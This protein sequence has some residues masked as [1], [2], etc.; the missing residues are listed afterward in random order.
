[1]KK[2][3]FG[4]AMAVVAMMLAGFSFTSCDEKDNAIIINGKEWVKAEVTNQTDG[5]ATIVANTPSDVNRMLMKIA[6]DINDATQAG[7]DYVITIEAPSMES[8]ES[9]NTI[10]IPLYDYLT[11]NP[12][13][14]AKVV[15]NFA[16][17]VNTSDEP[18]KIQAKGATGGAAPTSENKVEINLPSTSSGYDLELFMPKSTVTL[19][20]GTIDELVATTAINTL[21]IESG[22]TVNW[23]KVKDGRV[24]VKDGGKVLGY[25]R[26]GDEAEKRGNDAWAD[27]NGF[28]PI[29]G[30]NGPDVYYLDGESEEP[31][32]VQKLKVIKGE[33]AYAW[34]G[35]SNSFAE[36]ALESITIEDGA[37]IALDIWGQNDDNSNWVAPKGVKLIQGLGNKTAKIYAQNNTT[38]SD[39]NNNT[40]WGAY[41]SALQY[42]NEINNVTVNAAFLPDAWDWNGNSLGDLEL[43]FGNINLGPNSTDCDFISPRNIYGQVKNNV[44]SKVTNCTLTCP[45]DKEETNSWL[46]TISAINSKLT[47]DYITNMSPICENTTFKAKSISFNNYYVSG[48][49]STIKGCKFETTDENPSASISLPYQTANRSSFNFTFDTCDFAKGFKLNVSYN[50]N[51]PWLDKDGKPVTKAFYWN[52]L[53]E[54]GN[55][56]QDENYNTI[57]KKSTNEDDVPEANK[58]N[59]KSYSWSWKGYWEVN[60]ENG[61]TEESYFKDYKGIITFTDT[62]FDG[63]AITKDTEFINYVGSGENEKGEIATVTR[64]IIGGVSYKAVRDTDTQKY[65]LVEAE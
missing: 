48:N 2:N 22:V 47:A 40:I 36:N 26:N 3:F 60:N 65:T 29:F 63:K 25:L 19:N 30:T 21:I 37:A 28:N 8:S 46:E 9:D 55:V 34:V 39:N 20:A 15:V 61:L 45:V 31:Y 23:L 17:A 1:M 35:I 33:A 38:S 53:D 51:K 24:L 10:S 4:K 57:R 52:E 50:G 59:G 5:G 7:K 58:A 43:K 44:M 6:K 41:F 64:F 14:E 62:K 49:S 32:Y 11:A 18:L 56:K 42:T 16:N 54:N 27:K 13:S 12:T